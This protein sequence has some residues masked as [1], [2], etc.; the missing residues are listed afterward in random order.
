MA[1]GAEEKASSNAEPEAIKEHDDPGPSPEEH[2]PPLPPRPKALLPKD[3]QSSPHGS[4][5]SPASLRPRLASQATTAVSRPEVQS[6]PSHYLP[7]QVAGSSSNVDS[8]PG[9]SASPSVAAER[10]NRS[11]MS[12]V[13][14]SWSIRSYAPTIEASG[15]VQSLLGEI[16]NES[17]ERRWGGFEDRFESHD[18]ERGLSIRH[19]V[20]LDFEDE[21]ADVLGD[22]REE[23]E[24]L[25]LFQSKYKH[26]FILST[27]GKPIYTRHGD[28]GLISSEIGVLQTIIASH[29]SAS[30]PIKTF[31]AGPTRFVI[32]TEGPLHLVA[33]SRNLGETE[34]HLRSQLDALYMQILSTLTLP[35]LSHLFTNRPS[36][37]LQRPLQGTEALLS[38][39]SDAFTQGSPSTLLSA[40]ECLKLRK[41]HRALISNTLL[42]S[43][44]PH[45]LYGLLVAGGRL[46]SVVRPKRHSLHPGDL[47]LIFNMLFE[48]GSVQ[49]G[50]A[51]NW[52]PLCL[53]GFN[54]NG[55]LYMYVNFLDPEDGETLG[56]EATQSPAKEDQIALILISAEKES[57]YEM[58]QMRNAALPLLAKNGSLAVMR[59]AIRAGRPTSTELVPGTPV[60]HFLY[61]SKANVQYVM[62]S[63][64]PRYSTLLDRRRLLTTY[65]HLHGSV[66]NKAANIKVQL[67]S[68]PF[69]V[70]LAWVTPTFELFAV[71]SPGTGRAA[72]A[73][74][75]E[76][77]ICWVKREEERIFILG[78]AT[79]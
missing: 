20:G 39:L 12:E 76:G 18:L 35:G 46:V 13:D 57:F 23:E 33:I 26:F 70:G 69:N 73:R 78:G 68:G 48:A 64:L 50:G 45:L 77:I 58:Q 19:E 53:P 1:K 40:L 38:A 8:S 74:G 47:Q 21:F 55:Y 44:A 5:P 32:R 79:F 7:P 63:Y 42:R 30:S 25:R 41:A 75:V 16:L 10:R 52:I 67:V 15:D 54:K 4:K 49:A 2:C 3:G 34:T 6:R 51:E 43:R 72:I 17:G 14:D 60:E 59:E 22:G 27:A 9:G 61:R 62:P 36:T 71:A 28:K 65:H 56:E 24:A 37:D 29:D 66:H 31:T 11:R